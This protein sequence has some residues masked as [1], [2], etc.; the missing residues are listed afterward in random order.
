[1]TP[2]QILDRILAPVAD[3]LTPEMAQRLVNL[4]ADPDMQARIDELA[5]K[6]TDGELTHDERAEYETYVH[7][8]GFVAVLQANARRILNQSGAH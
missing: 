6:N 5:S 8:A 1:M 4:R 2:T 7:A 3:C